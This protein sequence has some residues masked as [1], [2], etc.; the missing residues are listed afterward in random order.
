VSWIKRTQDNTQKLR[1]HVYDVVG[2]EPFE[3]RYE[4]LLGLQFKPSVE[5][6]PTYLCKTMEQAKSYMEIFREEGYEGA[7]LRHGDAGYEDGKRSKSLVKIKEWHD[8]E[9]V[10]IDI[11]RS[12]DGWG[13]LVMKRNGKGFR[14]SAPGSLAEKQ[15]AWA[16]RDA[17]VG[18]YV[19]IEYAYI[20][21]DG[22]PFHPVAKCWRDI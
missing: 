20:T 12:K 18:R 2:Y 1:Y 14:A 10:V 6:V 9:F 13:I 19:T 5:V 17:F 3:E 15:A 21:K 16:H 11:E 22:V 7:I 4:K 8:E